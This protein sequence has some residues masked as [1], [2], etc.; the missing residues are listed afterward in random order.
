MCGIPPSRHTSLSSSAGCTTSP[1]P[2]VRS[3]V[4][5]ERQSGTV[6]EAP[7]SSP[8]GNRVVPDSVL[9]VAV[10]RPGRHSNPTRCSGTA[11]PGEA[12]V[13]LER[14]SGTVREAPTSKPPDNRVV[15][16]SVLRVAVDLEGHNSNST[17]I[18]Q[19]RPGIASASMGETVVVAFQALPYQLMRVLGRLPE[20]SV[21]STREESTRESAAPLQRQTRLSREAREEMTAAYLAGASVSELCSAYKVHRTTAYAILGAAD[22]VR[23]PHVRKMTDEDVSI[24]VRMYAAGD[25][26]ATVARVFSVDPTT[27]R[28]EL[29]RAGVRLRPRRGRDDIQTVFGRSPDG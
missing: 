4:A 25:S 22:A 10:D 3:S 15:P 17:S 2:N 7:T 16:D 20:W 8:P 9:R 6:R 1:R 18:P 27:V 24:A 21:E 26:L 14:R 19:H 29:F 13:A 28:R 5:S 23:P 11:R 12:C